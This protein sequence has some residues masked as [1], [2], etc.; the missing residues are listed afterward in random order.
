MF[1]NLD[2]FSVSEIDF[3]ISLA[4]ERAA[5]VLDTKDPIV[6]S[7]IAHTIATLELARAVQQGHAKTREGLDYVIE[8]LQGDN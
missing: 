6:I 4:Q 1:L 3:I 8:A 7:N 2:D 5:K